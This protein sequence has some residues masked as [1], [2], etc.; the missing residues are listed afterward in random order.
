ML[1]FTVAEV[2]LHVCNWVN[3]DATGFTQSMCVNV[4]KTA[5]IYS[6]MKGFIFFYYSLFSYCFFPVILAGALA[7]EQS[8]YRFNR[9]CFHENECHMCIE[10][11]LSNS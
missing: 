2:Q 9:I 3:N 6:L 1:F 11:W 7:I 4:K 10:S 8:T 5:F